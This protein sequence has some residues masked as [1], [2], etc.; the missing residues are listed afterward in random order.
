MTLEEAYSKLQGDYE[1]VMKLLR[2]PA[3]VKKFALKFIDDESFELLEKSLNEKK[4][5]EAFRAAHTLKGVCLNLC[6]DKLYL[7]AAEMTE[8]LRPGIPT[9][10]T[11]EIF[12]RL[13]DDYLITV[14]ALKEL[15]EEL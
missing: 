4:Y 13:K 11:E 12:N 10:K 7:S 9:D 14:S 6:F 3:L 5:T 2:N 15:S 8:D 1:K